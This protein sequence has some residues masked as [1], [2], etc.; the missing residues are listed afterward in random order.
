[1]TWNWPPVSLL[2][3]RQLQPSVGTL[4]MFTLVSGRGQ[5]AGFQGRWW[6]EFAVLSEET[7]GV[8]RPWKHRVLGGTFPKCGVTPYP[9]CSPPQPPPSFLSSAHRPFRPHSVKLL[10]PSCCSE[11]FT[12]SWNLGPLPSMPGPSSPRHWANG[13]GTGANASA[14]HSSH[15]PLRML[16]TLG[17]TNT[18]M[19]VSG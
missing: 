11:P 12:S 13:Q 9:L 7:K 16:V 5:P 10:P 2:L 15:L 14:P 18:R 1:M 8:F 4:Q 3:G 17:H 6:P 19:H